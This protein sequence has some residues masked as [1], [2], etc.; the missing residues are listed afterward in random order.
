MFSYNER[1]QDR[2]FSI[3]ASSRFRCSSGLNWGLLD[4]DK[5]AIFV[6]RPPDWRTVRPVAST[7]HPTSELQ[8]LEQT[9]LPGLEHHCTTEPPN[10]SENSAIGITRGW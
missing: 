3:G 9:L 10:D 4:S 6:P 5:S 1:N 2:S 8:D 7:S